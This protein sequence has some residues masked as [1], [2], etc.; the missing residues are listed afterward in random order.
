M[1]TTPPMWKNYDSGISNHKHTCLLS[2]NHITC[3]NNELI[4]EFNIFI[5][6]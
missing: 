4:P 1:I 2:A 3:W 6:K 5:L